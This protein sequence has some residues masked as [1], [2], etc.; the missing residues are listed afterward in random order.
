MQKENQQEKMGMTPGSHI[1]VL[2]YGGMKDF[3][4]NTGFKKVSVWSRAYLPFWGS[5][6]DLLC[7]IDRWHGHFLISTGFKEYR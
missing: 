3:L 2:A 7:T 4:L 6:S 1:R 5:V